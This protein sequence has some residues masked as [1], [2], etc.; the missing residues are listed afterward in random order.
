MYKTV[1][2]THVGRVIRIHSE[3]GVDTYLCV[4]GTFRLVGFNNNNGVH[5]M[6]IHNY[7]Y[8]AALTELNG[9]GRST[10]ESIY[11][12][13]VVKQALSKAF[14]YRWETNQILYGVPF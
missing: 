9:F 5:T 7:T 10:L 6:Y 8:K 1:A 14:M 12:K 4:G 11:S 2:R 13:K 3:R